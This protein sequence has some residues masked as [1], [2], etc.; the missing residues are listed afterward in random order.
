[1]EVA[2]K[3]VEKVN[4]DGSYHVFLENFTDGIRALLSFAQ[5]K[6]PRFSRRLRAIFSRQPLFSLEVQDRKPKEADE[7]RAATKEAESSSLRPKSKLEVLEPTRPNPRQVKEDISV[8]AIR[9]LLKVAAPSYH[10]NVH[11]GTE[12]LRLGCCHVGWPQHA[13]SVLRSSRQAAAQA[14][15]PIMPRN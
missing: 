6:A 9:Y 4:A 1:M 2:F 14:A 12:T 10:P 5:C 13:S 11:V 8:L 15:T 7:K 3:V